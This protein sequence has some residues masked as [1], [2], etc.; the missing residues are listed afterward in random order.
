MVEHDALPSLDTLLRPLSDDSAVGN[1][2][3]QDTSP[4]SLYYRIRDARAEARAEERIAD[5]DP[6]ASSGPSPHWTV[7]SDCARVALTTQTRDLEIAVWWMESLVRKIGLVGLTFGAQLVSGLVGQFWQAGLF[8]LMDEDGFEGRI[9]PIAGLSGQGG[10]GT[11]MQPLR[12]LVLF[13]RSNGTPLTFWEFEQARQIVSI[14]EDARKKLRTAAPLV[15]FRDLEVQASSVGRDALAALGR[16]VAAAMTAW[17][18]M[19]ASLDEAVG[20]Q[21]PSTRDIYEFLKGL[22][23]LVARF[24]PQ[25]EPPAPDETATD[26]ESGSPFE[27]PAQPLETREQMLQEISRIAAS[28]RASEPNSPLGYTLDDAVRRARMPWPDLLRE[29]IPELPPRSAL[30]TSLGIKPPRE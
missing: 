28:F 13:H 14:K 25:E 5:S 27:R 29:M 10:N 22:R 3:R 2:L 12:K 6:E 18:A 26:E 19:Q 1:D 30:L 9:A 11:L 4:Q 17:E 7:V 8:P 24:V 16:E 20:N 21:A 15:E 23:A